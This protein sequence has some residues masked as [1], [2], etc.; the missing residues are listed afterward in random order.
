[1]KNTGKWQIAALVMAIIFSMAS[2]GELNEP[3]R[4]NTVHNH[5]D[6]SGDSLSS[7]NDNR[8]KDDPI[9]APNDDDFI[10]FTISNLDAKTGLVGLTAAD[11]GWNRAFEEFGFIRDGQILV[12]L[13]K[14][15]PNVN[16]I[17]P[18]NYN[19]VLWFEEYD[20][21]YVY[22]AGANT[23]DING[24][25]SYV[26]TDS[27]SIT[28][29]QFRPIALPLHELTVTGFDY[30]FNTTQAWAFVLN[31]D[32]DAWAYGTI[33]NGSLKGTMRKLFN[34]R[35]ESAS[36]RLRLQIWRGNYVYELSDFT[37]KGSSTSVDISQF[38]SNHYELTI[39]GVSGLDGR[40]IS[41]SVYNSDDTRLNTYLGY[42][43]SS[44]D[45]L[46]VILAGD[47]GWTDDGPF[48]LQLSMRGY[49]GMYELSD[50]TPTGNASSVDFSR[51]KRNYHLLTITGLDDLLHNG[52]F[53]GREILAHV[54]N[55][56]NHIVAPWAFFNAK[57]NDS[58][59]FMLIGDFGWTESGSP[60]RLR[61][62]FLGE[63]SGLVYELPNF[64]PIGSASSVDFGGFAAK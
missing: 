14:M 42:A 18:G 10:K 26:V 59:S 6:K 9:E 8:E 48:R 33:V 39:T 63:L 22:T 57:E 56:N 12:H 36:L 46:T 24:A 64:V 54:Y 17:E 55:A 20:E 58:I 43:T 41:A 29:D 52:L 32:T 38:K 15:S 5:D 47:F 50:F 35:T 53:H 28:F 60:F 37:M 7:G 51:F 40:D 11:D 19:I 2:C 4:N 21:Y 27:N 62:E 34:A 25:Q 3:L 13:R 61:L 1:M 16:G 30:W 45:N 44:G 31:D 23:N 49:N